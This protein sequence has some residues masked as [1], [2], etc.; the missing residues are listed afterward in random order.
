MCCES[1]LRERQL[2]RAVLRRA[3]CVGWAC[4]VF[5]E[6]GICPRGDRGDQSAEADWRS[7]TELP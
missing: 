4:L 2:K 3:F 5:D 7:Y 1:V 6:N